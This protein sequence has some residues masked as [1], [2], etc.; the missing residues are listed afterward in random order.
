L[1]TVNAILSFLGVIMMMAGMAG[2]SE[3]GPAPSGGGDRQCYLSPTAVIAT[4]DEGTLF[5]ACPTA[6]RVL[7]LDLPSRKLSASL[8]VP[9]SPTGL[10]L[11]KDGSRLFVTCAAPE[12]RV[13]VAD[14]ANGRFVEEIRAGHTAMAPV[15]SADGNQLFV[16]NR[17]NNDVSV[18]DLQAKKEVRRIPVQREPVAAV[19]TADG[20]FLL[21]ANSLPTGRADAETVA[22]VVSV[23]DVVAGKVSKQLQLPDGSASLNDIRV[24]HD[25]RYAVVTH[26]LSRYHLPA[27]Q[28]ERGWMNANAMT[29][30]G[31][32]RMEVLNTILLDDLENGAANPWAAAWSRDGS[33]L[34]ITHAGTHEI[35][36][37]AFP[38]LV[39]K[40]EGLPV[41][42][43]AAISGDYGSVARVKADVPNDLAFLT[44][45]RKRI[46]LS[47]QDRGPRAVTIVG[48]TAYIANYF[49]DTISVVDLAA[50]APSVT[51]IALGPMVEPTVARKGEFYF[52]DATICFQ[53]W[54]SCSSCHPGDGRTDGLN[55]DLPNDGIG[56]PK[57]TKSLLLAYKTPP[58]M[59]LGVRATAEIAVR[60]GLEHILFSKQP[61]EVAVAIDE[62]LKSLKPVPSPSLVKGKPSTAA[63]RGKAI[64]QRAGCADCHPAGLFTDLRK[65]DVGTRRPFDNPS[66][67]F[68]TPTLIELWRTAP[69][70]HDG[71]AATIRDV[72]TTRNFHDQHGRTS[73]LTNPEVEDL[74]E[75]LNSL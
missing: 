29:I 39:A 48:A 21:V 44:D 73:D 32:S 34:V 13:W 11:S 23:I 16:C 3:A 30:I 38:A 24:S 70:L 17:F 22:A 45:L 41:S 20:K 65:H 9:S 61:E 10:A 66:D 33:K 53:H 62:Y 14:A 37:I 5:I 50:A 52:H 58:V 25:G 64:F 74:C 15:V 72:L 68:N 60:A 51:S 27:N 71:S 19:L 7:R 35:S 49:S 47:E 2:A 31:L 36:V 59:S 46:P 40:L 75:Y 26:V 1:F 57:N 28:L 42:L 67:R 4:K 18:I 8:E 69:Y 12:S 6:N 54:Q 63:L 56:N 43:K 55:W